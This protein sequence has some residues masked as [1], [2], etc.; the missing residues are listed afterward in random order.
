MYYKEF[1]INFIYSWY[2]L[3]TIA[4]IAGAFILSVHVIVNQNIRIKIQG[5]LTAFLSLNIEDE[6]RSKTPSL[7]G[8]DE[9]ESE[10]KISKELDE[11]IEKFY[12]KIIEKFINVWYEK[13]SSDQILIRNVSHELA[14]VSREIWKR[15]IK[16]DHSD[17]ILKKLLPVIYTHIEILGRIDD[18][19]QTKAIQNFI[20]GQNFIHPSTLSRNSELEYLR[21]LSKSILKILVNRNSIRCPLVM[22]LLKEILSSCLFLPL[23]DVICDPSIINQLVMLAMAP[24]TLNLKKKMES[25]QEK[26]DML[27]NFKK[28]H[29]I[30]EVSSD[31]HEL[32]EDIENDDFLR[33][34]DNLYNFMQYLKMNDAGFIDL[35]KFYLDA[36]QLI[37]G[38]PNSQDIKHDSTKSPELK[39][40]SEQLL[41]FY[42]KKLFQNYSKAIESDKN[43]SKVPE[44]L[45]EA[46]Q[47]SKYILRC[48]WKEDYCKSPEYFRLIYGAKELNV[49]STDTHDKTRDSP[50]KQSTDANQQKFTS[51]M[52]NVMKAETVEGL[53]ATEI[54]IFDALDFSASPSSYFG[55][56]SVKM[57]R[58]KGQDLENFMQALFQSIEQDADLGEDIISMQLKNDQML[59][60]R[61]PL[62]VGNVELYGNLFNSN[63]QSKVNQFHSI[64]SDN[65]VDTLLYFLTSV[66]NLGDFPLRIVKGIFNFFPDSNKIIYKYLD[67]SLKK[68][69]DQSILASLIAELHEKIFDENSE[70]NAKILEKILLTKI[71]NKNARKALKYFQNAVLNKNL[72]YCLLDVI[73]NELFPELESLSNVAKN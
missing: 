23:T 45:H 69:C 71:E 44:N 59:S 33:S 62:F 36:E 41:N 30:V 65:H 61:K 29:A 70:K 34:Q 64:Q 43:Y 67:K 8:D 68:A 6:N 16:I 58:E 47:H 50:Q 46:L 40:K 20:D 31:D 9:D 26:V 53:E 42:R 4:T 22:E 51:K 19:N 38:E 18:S 1:L 17:L 2:G 14:D 21:S 7:F 39:K 3:V 5:F 27:E 32:E 11:S 66:M 55:P 13:I 10:F 35:L 54:P 28:L 72:M 24:N 25:S 56:V 63:D 15:S 57:R 52:K 37:T 73:V 49:H 60:G 12:T 48:K